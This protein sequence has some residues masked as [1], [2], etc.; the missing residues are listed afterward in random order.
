MIIWN[1]IDLEYL[2][3]WKR[4]RTLITMRA[5]R[6]YGS[7]T[8]KINKKEFNKKKI[9]LVFKGTFMIIRKRFW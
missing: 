2:E 1:K 8:V 6:F 9:D 5:T 7:F 4:M 3:R